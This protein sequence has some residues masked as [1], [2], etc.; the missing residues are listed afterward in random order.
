[1]TTL[2]Q[3]ELSA[4]GQLST[5]TIDHMRNAAK[6]MRFVAIVGFCLC[7]LMAILSFVLPG[8]LT[9]LGGTT[10]GDSL[11]MPGSISTTLTV[12]YL[13]F[14]VIFFI[15]NLFLFQSAK[16]F[17]RYVAGIEMTDIENGFRKLHSLF[18]FFGILIIIY[19]V[20]LV[21]ALL[22]TLMFI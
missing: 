11:L 13:V 5:A 2:D 14:A 6:W 10:T 9:N 4:S 16:H 15:P 21:I 3:N 18:L 8:F 7:A 12:V 20:I 22:G 17:S 1:M 19:I